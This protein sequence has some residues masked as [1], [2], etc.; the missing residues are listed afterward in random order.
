[1]S[2]HLLCTPH[3]H[4]YMKTLHGVQQDTRHGT[5]MPSLL[6]SLKV[7]KG[8]LG[9][10]SD[11]NRTRERINTFAF[12]FWLLEGTRKTEPASHPATVS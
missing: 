7:Q 2:Q 1:M 10:S 3:L 9:Y 8:L 4:A 6:R 12:V 11:I 5:L